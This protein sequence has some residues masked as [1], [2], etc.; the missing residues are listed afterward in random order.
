MDVVVIR[1]LR[2]QAWERAKG[3]LNAMMAA[4]WP[5]S[6]NP[7]TRDSEKFNNLQ[8]AVDSFIVTMEDEELYA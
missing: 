6:D 3:E 7:P 1:T 8:A 4:T 2:M 5:G